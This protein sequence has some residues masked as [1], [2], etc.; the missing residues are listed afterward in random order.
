MSLQ[1]NIGSDR[2]WVWK[3]AADFAEG[4]PTAE[5]LAIR[6]ANSESASRGTADAPDRRPHPLFPLPADAN[7]FKEKF[8]EAKATNAGLAKGASAEETKP[9]EEQPAPAE[10]AKEEEAEKTVE[11][12]KAD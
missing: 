4:E 1:P 5:T 11:E 9:S 7:Q 12:T 10:S 2:S 3:V 6:F 8:D